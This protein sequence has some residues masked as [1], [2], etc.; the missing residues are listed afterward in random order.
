MPEAKVTSSN[1]EYGNSI[2]KVEFL[3]GDAQKDDIAKDIVDDFEV[4]DQQFARGA[5]SKSED[6]LGRIFY[7][8]I[9]RILENRN[10]SAHNYD[11]VHHD[12]SDSQQNNITFPLPISSPS[13]FS[14][15]GAPFSHPR[16]S[17]HDK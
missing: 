8:E 4:I 6:Y 14:V 16:R 12:E 1:Y 13:T 10:G 15:S 7:P 17:V 3:F 9:R 5:Y 2:S 11:E